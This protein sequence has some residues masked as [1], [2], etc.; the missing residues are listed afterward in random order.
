MQV[1]RVWYLANKEKAQL[2]AGY[3]YEYDALQARC[4]APVEE[5]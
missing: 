2:Q 3:Q 5:L 4:V 1:V